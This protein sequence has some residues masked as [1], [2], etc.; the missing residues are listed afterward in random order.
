MWRYISDDWFIQEVKGGEVGSST[1]PQKV[2]PIDFE[3]AESYLTLANGLFTVFESK[4]TANRL[5]RDIVDKYLARE[6][7]LGTNC[8]NFRRKP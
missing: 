3:M 4:L 1:M 8:I 6:I 7:N 2:N 5:Q